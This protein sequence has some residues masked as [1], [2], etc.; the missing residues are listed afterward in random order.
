MISN[1]VPILQMRSSFD[2]KSQCNNDSMSNMEVSSTV[3]DISLYYV[4][5]MHVSPHSM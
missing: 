3:M 2:I 5:C 1:V 4:K